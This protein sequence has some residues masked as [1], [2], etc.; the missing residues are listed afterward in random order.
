MAPR[1]T[2]TKGKGKGKAPV[3]A[4]PSNYHVLAKR[5]MKAKGAQPR[6]S[7]DL[8]I[9]RLL[10]SRDMDEPTIKQ[11]E[12]SV[13][14]GPSASAAAMLDDAGPG[15]GP[16]AAAAQED[17]PSA[18]DD[19]ARQLRRLDSVL[20]EV[21]ELRRSVANGTVTAY[22]QYTAVDALINQI[23][24]RTNRTEDM[25]G[26]INQ[27]TDSM[28]DDL[29]TMLETVDEINTRTDTIG[30]SVDKVENT[31]DDIDRRTDGMND[32]LQTVSEA[33]SGIEATVDATANDVT[34]VEDGIGQIRTENYAYYKAIRDRIGSMDRRIDHIL[35]ILQ[36][37]HG[38]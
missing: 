17:V 3:V 14:A 1:K 36:D 26:D 22:S 19:T 11:E 35:T 16:G 12:G 28:N 4:G 20:A 27:R 7:F 33:I 2:A 18:S 5:T 8:N 30:D 34:N 32:D 38:Y 21:Q 9:Q 13:A 29:Q 15:P 24:M 10:D 25:A 6:S 31:V 37:V 23:H